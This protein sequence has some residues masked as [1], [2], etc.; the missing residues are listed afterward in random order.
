MSSFELKI[1]TSKFNALMARLSDKTRW[2]TILRTVSS[3][4][5]F[6]E[7]IQHFRDEKGPEGPWPDWSPAYKQY[8]AK[9]ANR[10]ATPSARKRARASGVQPVAFS[11]KLVL[12]GNLRQSFMT[13]F[14]PPSTDEVSVL[15]N[16][17]PYS[18]RHDRGTGGMPQR[19]FM[20]LGNSGLELIAKNFLFSLS[21]EGA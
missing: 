13:P 20:W 9:L 8:R 6:K 11:K 14:A 7:V 3:V 18:R 5:A 4:I 16:H 21:R 10:L 2:R 15:S 19:Q 1:D 12:T 17:Q